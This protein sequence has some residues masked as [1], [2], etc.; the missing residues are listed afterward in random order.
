MLN[1]PPASDQLADYDAA[2]RPRLL[3]VVDTEEEFPWNEPHSRANTSVSAMAD[4][5]R[6]QDIFDHYAVRPAYV[7]DYPV[8]SQEEGYGPLESIAAS[9]R[10]VIGAHLHPWVTPPLTEPVNAAN[11][12]PGNLD[13]G[14]EEEKL[15][16]LTQTIEKRFV[17]PTIYKAGRYG[18]GPNTAN[19][20]AGL[21]YDIDLSPTPGFSYSGE[22]GP[23]FTRH[24]CSPFWFDGR[25]RLCIP[26]TGGFVGALRGQGRSLYP[27][28]ANPLASRLRLGGIF[29][30]LGLLER[31][32]LS[33]EGF[34]L[35]DMIKLTNQL[36]HTAGV[37]TFTLS[38]H[39]PTLRIGC[40]PYVRDKRDLDRFLASIE[41]YLE[42]FF[43]ELNG[44]AVTPG[45]VKADL[46]S[47]YA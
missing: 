19:I 24:P 8:A 6:G 38:F 17:R 42:Y 36:L 9:D 22:G 4:V 21:G 5:G 43:N 23:D 12:F 3:V 29:S 10:C 40:T 47:A 30:R 13:K 31:I 33:P 34:S 20:L 1:A 18:V 35:P 41:G 46:Q 45:E 11:S 37:R 16:I 27:W 7:I 15:A 25:E 44:V 14:L 39:S 28:V 2:E 32:R 26:C